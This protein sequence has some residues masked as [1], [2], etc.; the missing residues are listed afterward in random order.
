MSHGAAAHASLSDAAHI[1]VG[2]SAGPTDIRIGV[3]VRH[4]LSALLEAVGLPP[5]GGVIVDLEVADN[6]AAWT[7][8]AAGGR[9]ANLH[10]LPGGEEAKRRHHWTRLVDRFIE[11]GRHQPL[12]AIGGGAVLDVAG[13]AAS[14]IRRGLPWVAVPTTVV[15]MADASVGGKTAVN[16]ERG[17]NLIGSFHP[18]RAVLADPV[19]LETL[20]ERDRTAGLAEIYKSARLGDTRLLQD[21][22]T[23]APRTPAAWRPLLRRAI[24]CKRHFV[25]GD[26]RDQG[27][28]RLLNLGHTVGHALETVLGGE[29]IRHGEAV[30]LGMVAAAHLAAA[31]DWIPIEIAQRYTADLALLGLPTEAPAGTDVGRVRETLGLDK[32]RTGEL[33]TFILPVGPTEARVADDVREAEVD[34][35]LAAI[36]LA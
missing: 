3:G 21:L 36:G 34:L 23:G 17:K 4:G 19:F 18:P 5:P 26:L 8:E 20:P 12:V 11:L 29:A 24:E 2:A 25:E 30:S 9:E 31:R 14:T 32:K 33:H 10:I 1:E 7:I 6:W 16:H 28:R 35:A 27:V 15:A 13:F 22:A